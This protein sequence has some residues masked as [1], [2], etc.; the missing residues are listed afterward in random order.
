MIAPI[1]TGLI[2]RFMLNNQ[3]G[4]V[5]KLLYDFNFTSSPHAIQWLSDERYSLLSAII[6]D[7]WLTTPFMMLVLL[8]GLQGISPT[9]YESAR[10]DGAN[11]IQIFFSITIP[12][13]MPVMVVAI[14]IR[15]ID[16]ARTFD[17]VWVLTQGGPAFS[18]EVLS[19][20]MYSNL[21]RYGLVGESSAMAV[22]FII[23]LLALSSYFLVNMFRANKK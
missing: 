1:V 5:N 19:T 17:I 21:T 6:A 12:S 3:F 9:L 8:A 18:S 2:W 13:L 4:I 16:A 7:I 11:K 10:I 15:M 23:I 20:Y 14:L 22:I